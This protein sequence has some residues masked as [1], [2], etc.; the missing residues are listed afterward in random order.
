MGFLVVRILT[1]PFGLLECRQRRGGRRRECPSALYLHS[2]H[3]LSVTLD[4]QLRESLF[5]MAFQPLFP[6]P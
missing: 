3:P 1:A 5:L 2:T 4:H 6:F